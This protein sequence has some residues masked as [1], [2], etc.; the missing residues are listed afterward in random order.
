MS[1]PASGQSAPTYQI[2][3]LGPIG[4]I[5]EFKFD[6]EDFETWVER[7]E[8]YMEINKLKEKKVSV[9]LTLVGSKAYEILRALCT[10]KKPR[11]IV[12][13]ELVSKLLDYIKPKP[14]VLAERS[15]FRARVQQQNESASAFIAALQKLSQ[16]CDFKDN[17]EESLRDQITH[18]IANNDLKK[19]LF[20]EKE[21][22]YTKC[23]E[24]IMAWEGMETS[25]A[26]EGSLASSTSSVNQVKKNFANNKSFSNNKSF[27]NSKNKCSCCGYTNHEFKDC[28]FKEKTC[29]ICQKKGHLSK[30]CRQKGKNDNDGQSKVKSQNFVRKNKKNSDNKNEKSNNF[31]NEDSDNNDS[32]FLNS[33]CNV[34][35]ESSSKKPIFVT[36][37]I[38]NV[39]IQMEVDTG[40]YVAAITNE[41]YL[42][43]FENLELKPIIHELNSYDGTPLKVLGT[44]NVQGTYNKV[45]ADNLRLFVVEGAKNALFG[46]EWFK[47]FKIE[48]KLEQNLDV[49]NIN[50][51]SLID[52]ISDEF[53]DVINDKLGTYT[54]RLINVVTKENAKPKFM[55]PY[56]L[57]YKIKDKVAF[58]ID[59]LVAQKRFIPVETSEHGSPIVPVPKGDGSLRICGDYKN[60]V[61]PNLVI[62]RYP[63]PLPEDLFQK[64]ANSNWFSK[65]DLSHAY[66]QMLLDEPSRKLLTLSTHKGLFQPTRLMYGVASAP[67][68][69]QR[70]IE[71]LFQGMPF[72]AC[73]QDDILIGGTDLD[74]HIENL[75]KVL[76]KLKDCGLTLNRNKCNFLKN[77]ISYLGY[78]VN[79]DGIF[80]DESKTEAVR[81][82]PRPNNVNELQSFLGLVS[83]LSKF[84][85]NASSLLYPL[86]QLLHKD[87]KWYWSKECEISFNKVKEILTD[88]NFLIHF[89]PNMPL[90]LKCDASPYGLGC[91][92]MHEKNNME[93]PVAYASRSLN[94]AEK[95]YSQLDKEALSIIFA[96]QKFHKYLYGNTFC[97][98]TDHKPLTYI[99]NKNKNCP[100]V[101]A[102]RLQRYAFIL[103]DYDYQIEYIPS[104]KNV[105]A[106][107]LSRLPLKKSNDAEEVSYVNF[108]TDIFTNIN[109]DIIA[110]ETAKDPILSK[111]IE[112]L[113]TGWP[114][115]KIKNIDKKFQPYFLKKNELNFELGCLFF[116]HKVIIPSS[117]QLKILN[118]LHTTHLGVVKMKSTARSYF[119]W[120][121]LDKEIEQLT[122]NCLSCLKFSNRPS[123][124]KLHQWTYPDAP[125]KRIHSD[126]CYLDN[127][128]FLIITDQYS[129]WIEIYHV[130]QSS[131]AKIVIN[132]FKD[133]FSRWGISEVLVTD[134]GPPFSSTEFNSFM[135]RNGVN[136]IFTP[137]Y[138][139]QSNGAAEN[140]VSVFKN[141]IKKA[142][143]SGVEIFDAIFRFLL[144]FRTTV[145]CTT[146][147][148]P[149]ELHVNRKLR[150]RFDIFVN[151]K[152]ESQKFFFQGR[153]DVTAE[154]GDKVMARDYKQGRES[155]IPGTIVNQKGNVTFDVKTQDGKILKRHSDQL[156]PRGDSVITTE[157]LEKNKSEN[158]E[159]KDA[160]ESEILP[161]ENLDKSFNK[162][163]VKSDISSCE[164]RY[165]LRDRRPVDRY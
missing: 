61:N 45:N 145:H 158:F 60:T 34:V 133:Y 97:L 99:F 106:D 104:K 6:S 159:Q 19:K 76:N 24:L 116:S 7:L 9:F 87:K 68:I 115:V 123:K 113:K 79:K 92:L 90:K 40:S 101:V 48:V 140:C 155:W 52:N 70:E 18:G 13:D 22:S 156:I 103:A 162:E 2:S 119:W 71:K 141:K 81:S 38:E 29:N 3:A 143:D 114:S 127:K 41:I 129:K 80:S 124:V 77:E 27:T 10:P 46:R 150:T 36:V 100:Q 66:Q 16:T 25:M 94:N 138:H 121:T 32:L 136:H 31:V 53:K 17:L 134:N 49:K 30:M 93:Y 5:N 105:F 44:I 163:I 112:F 67:G 55:R 12:Y 89:N 69:F 78:K 83:Y 59:N 56:S 1:Q 125:G 153:K 146:N 98:Q 117:L 43:F 109:Q 107:M 157:E 164:R 42:K 23:R 57:P 64:I 149:A 39:P 21:L 147:K 160:I 15:K 84:I 142:L 165:P 154:I 126:F 110:Q 14:S 118:E 137:P 47:P 72:I 161:P 37:N 65:L 96:I 144:D 4:H 26:V 128:T 91:V 33:I 111:V 73:Y 135:K 28:Y 139:P 131:N 120:P 82:A 11:D 74:H 132:F 152:I 95:N 75:K 122:R 8:L 51:N 102:N 50:V 108:I 151:R 86:N 54:V 20:A 62:D 35:E 58:E 130:S 148:T 63:L 85:P 88:S